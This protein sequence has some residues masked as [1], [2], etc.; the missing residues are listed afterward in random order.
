MEYEYLKLWIKYAA[1]MSAV[2]G[3]VRGSRAVEDIA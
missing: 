3:R 2:K 1:N